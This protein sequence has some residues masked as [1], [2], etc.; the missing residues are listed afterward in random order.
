MKSPGAAAGTASTEERMPF[1]GMSPPPRLLLRTVNTMG[2][3]TRDAPRSRLKS[4]NSRLKSSL[5]RTGRPATMKTSS[6]IRQPMPSAC[7]TSKPVTIKVSIFSLTP[8]RLLKR[9]VTATLV[10]SVLAPPFTLSLRLGGLGGTTILSAISSR[11]PPA[12]GQVD[13]RA[14]DL[15]LAILT[16]SDFFDWALA[17]TTTT[18]APSVDCLLNGLL[19]FRA[20][21][22]GDTDGLDSGA[23]G[24]SERLGTCVP[25]VNC[26]ALFLGAM[27]LA[28]RDEARRPSFLPSASAGSKVLGGSKAARG[29]PKTCATTEKRP[30]S[31]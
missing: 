15:A 29:Q 7:G 4:S 9:V 23:R 16:A 2:K 18:P 28:E 11:G 14:L 27:R 5:F 12:A 24:V 13:G 17:G 26:V 25:L 8:S 10:T 21:S 19:P 22:L 1:A 31:P 20:L 30:D 6:P 3:A